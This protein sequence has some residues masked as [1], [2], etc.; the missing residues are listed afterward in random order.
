MVLS[1]LVNDKRCDIAA[2]YFKEMMIGSRKGLHQVELDTVKMY[3]ELDKLMNHEEY[4]KI[5][6]ADKSQLPEKACG[7]LAFKDGDYRSDGS[8]MIEKK[9]A[10]K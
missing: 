4:F 10:I 6:N 2:T 7:Q 9:E 1:V 3:F 8:Q 5:Y